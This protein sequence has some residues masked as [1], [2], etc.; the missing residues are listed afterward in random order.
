V[1]KNKAPT[2]LAANFTDTEGKQVK[3]NL[4]LWPL[5]SKYK[6]KG[7]VRSAASYSCEESY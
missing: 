4:C 7:D 3:R 6:G 5:V 2:T 1:E